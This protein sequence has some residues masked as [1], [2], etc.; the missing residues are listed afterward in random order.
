MYDHKDGITLRK[1]EREDL[2]DLF[3]LK[4]ESWWGTHKTLIINHD[5]QRQ[6]YQNIPSDQLFMIVYQGQEKVGVAVYTEIDH[7]SRTLNIAG[8]IYKRHRCQEVVK[9][10]FSAGLDFAFEILNVQ[11]VGAE[12]LATNRASQML[13]L[14]H[15]GFKIEGV[16]RR[17]G[18]KCGMYIDSL[19]LGLL[20]EEWEQQERV[21]GYNGSCCAT[22]NKVLMNKA[23]SRAPSPDLGRYT[24]PADISDDILCTPKAE[25]GQQ[26]GHA[27]GQY[28]FCP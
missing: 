27:G 25:Q 20:R 19:V 28:E 24:N 23:A 7:I 1:I 22:F 26:L 18:Y 3:C 8:S 13:E 14:N 6:W 11:R 10:A 15:L 17:A 16:R 5:E 4:Q 2:D 12:V 21:K 9:P